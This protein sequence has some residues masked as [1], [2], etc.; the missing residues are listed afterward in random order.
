MDRSSVGGLLEMSELTIEALKEKIRKV[1]EDIK[2]LN[3]EGVTG[4]K[5]EVLN[6]YK[7]YLEDELRFIKHNP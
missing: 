7:E 5:F 6:E 2:N 4:R 3:Q 1:E